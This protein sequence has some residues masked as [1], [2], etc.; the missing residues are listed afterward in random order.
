MAIAPARVPAWR[1]NGQVA[2]VVPSFGVRDRPGFAL[3]VRV[4]RG[5]DVQ[6]RTPALYP[7]TGCSLSRA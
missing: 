4:S 6:N 1:G 7:D 2:I 5:V 3:P